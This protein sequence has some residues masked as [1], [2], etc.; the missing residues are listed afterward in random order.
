MNR[1]LL[2]AAT[3]AGVAIAVARLAAVRSAHRHRRGDRRTSRRRAFEGA[4][5]DLAT[6]RE[7]TDR[8]VVILE[9][10]AARAHEP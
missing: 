2:A 8:I 6:I 10:A 1:L 5:H 3:V 9:D 7:N 4:V